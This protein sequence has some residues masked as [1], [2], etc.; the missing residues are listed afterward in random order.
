MVSSKA[1]NGT[2]SGDL[3]RVP[4]TIQYK[5]SGPPDYD[6]SLEIVK[7]VAT[8]A[9][10]G[11]RE[12]LPHRTG[13]GAGEAGCEERSPEQ[14]TTK[15]AAPAVSRTRRLV[16]MGLLSFG[17]F[18]LG[19][20]ISLQA[21]F[22]THEA[23][24]KG[25]SAT[26]SGFVFSVFELTIF[27]VAPIFAKL[28]AIVKPRFLL[29][30]GLF[31]VG[32]ASILFG[33]LKMSPPGS[34][35]LGLAIAV[36][37][38]EGL[39][40]AAF[41]TAVFSIVAAEFPK[42]LA[43]SYSMQQTAFGVGL[44]AGPTVGGILYEVGGFM[45]PFLSVGSLLLVCYVFAYLLLPPTENQ[46]QIFQGSG[47]MLRFWCNAGILLDAYCVFTTFLIIGFNSATL[48]PHLRQ[49][50]LEPSLVG[51]VFVLNGTVYACTA[52]IWGRMAD[53]T[54]RTKELCIV[55]CLLFS[56]SLLLVGP[57]PFIPLP[58]AIW[59]VM[60]ALAM[61]G[62]GSGGTIVCSFVG[63]FRDTLERGFPD[64]LSTYGLVS[65][66]FTVAHSL[67]A[68]VGPTLGGYLL[69]TVGYPMG[70]MVLLGNDI[71][72]MVAICIYVLTRPPSSSD[73]QHLLK[74]AT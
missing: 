51:L 31:Y 13:R 53:R 37:V 60:L 65:S 20:S 14:A 19:S 41:Q 8:S 5:A 42:S 66:V 35:F 73:R 45:L 59:T 24:I 58:T 16:I 25:V 44:V 70:S 6:A 29:L 9:C 27:L 17:N 68:F 26:E 28:V 10:D 72:L 23:Q 54:T 18:C 48:E 46:D 36:R 55:A 69:D 61:F 52:W 4:V 15:D 7:R 50:H 49:F 71:L 32:M 63:S 22:F 40:T 67:G 39:G 57:A 64:D 12:D 62:L 74:G 1:K 43:S 3:K 34:V 2:I 56:V 33:S 11:L 30:S 21:P 47:K 38:F